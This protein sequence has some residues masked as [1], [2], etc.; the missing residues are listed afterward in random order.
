MEYLKAIIIGIVQGF[1]EFLPVSSSGHI[2]LFQQILGLDLQTQ[3]NLLLLILLHLATALSTI[4]V[5]RR[6]IVSI[7][8]N[9]STNSKEFA[10]NYLLYIVVSML[11]AV[12]VGLYLKQ[13]MESLV[14]NLHVVAVSLMLTALLLL[15]AE[16]LNKRNKGNTDI[17]LISS[18]VMGFS[19]ALAALLPGLSRSG[20]TI[21]T[22]LLRG[23][24]KE[25]ATQ[26]SFLMV[27]P[28]ILGASAKMAL[29][30]ISHPQGEHIHLNYLLLTVSFT[31]AFLS[32]LIACRWMVRIVKNAKLYYFSIYCGAVSV[33]LLI[34]LYV[35]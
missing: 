34:Y 1:T 22:A 18:I 3:D 7:A 35:R 27:L 29:E 9:L 30:M 32:G 14:M 33:G 16:W 8:H 13:I 26:F 25:K 2:V 6:D 20:S 5:Y 17:N 28:L 31:A 15:L 23:T 10:R 4:V 19:Q 12:F 21:A 24:D 11:P